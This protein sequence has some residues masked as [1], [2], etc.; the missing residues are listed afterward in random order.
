VT[1]G[2]RFPRVALVVFA[3][4]LLSAGLSQGASAEASVTSSRA[5]ASL[6]SRYAV[7]SPGQGAARA[8]TMAQ[9]RA[10]VKADLSAAHVQTMAPQVMKSVET[11][12]GARGIRKARGK[13]VAPARAQAP[14][15]SI[16][17]DVGLAEVWGPGG[18]VMGRCFDIA[19][20]PAW[21]GDAYLGESLSVQA[22]IVTEPQG[23][24]V[25]G[26][27]VQVSFQLS[28]NGNTSAVFGVS[29]VF[30]PDIGLDVPSQ[31]DF[32]GYI[33]K[34]G[35]FTSPAGLTLSA[36]LCGSG[37]NANSG[38]NFQLITT[39]T[40]TDPG[41]TTTSATVSAYELNVPVTQT[42]AA[43]CS[44][45]GA[46]A[47][48]AQN[49]QLDPVATATGGCVEIA[50]DAIVQA[51]AV[52]MSV[53]RNYSSRQTAAGPLGPGW[54][55]PWFASAAQQGNGDVVITDENGDQ[56][57]YYKNG[58]GSFTGPVGARSALAAASPGW[59]WT[60]PDHRQ[61][62]FNGSGQ[63]AWVHDS[64]GRG[65]S[66]AYTGGQLATVMAASG[67]S[68]ALAYGSG[69][70]LASITLPGGKSVSYGY[71]SGGRLATATDATGNV[72]TYAYTSAGLL[73]SATDGAG[74]VLFTN[75]YDSGGRVTQQTDAAGNMA[76]FAYTPLGNGQ[77]ET[78]MTDPQ[79][80]IWTDVY[81]GNMLVESLNPAGT[82]TLHVANQFLQPVST[83][84]QNGGVSA[85]TYDGSGNRT[86]ATDADS[87]SQAWAYTGNDV[88]S[89]TSANGKV[90]GY[91][92]NAMHEQTSVTA[93][94]GGKTTYA[95]DSA[96]RLTSVTDPRG[97]AS[98]AT[99]S[100]Y[101]TTYAYDSAG[102]LAQKS[103]PLG[104]VNSY[105]YDAM[106]NLA[107]QTDPL[108]HVTTYAYDGDGRLLSV[109]SPASKVTRYAYDAAG[110][111]VSSTDPAG[112]V[113]R[114]AYDA[115]GQLTSTTDPL[116]NVTKYGYDARGNKTTATDPLDNVTNYAYDASNRL[117]SVTDPAGGVSTYAY[118]GDG[119][120]TSQTDP[121]GN[122]TT[123][124]FDPAGNVASTTDP[125]GNQTIYSYNGD[126]NNVST[127]DPLGNATTDAYDSDGRLASVTRPGGGA[128]TYAYD[129]AGNK[130]SVTNPDGKVGARFFPAGPVRLMDTR[131]G[132]GGTTGPVAAGATVR[133]QVA[134]VSGVPSSGVTSVVL[135]LTAVSPSG[136]GFLEAYPDGTTAPT[137][138]DV[139]FGGG[140]TVANMITVPLGADGKV[141]ILVGGTG[142]VQILADLA[143]YLY[144]APSAPGSVTTYAYDADNEMVSQADADGNVTRYAYNADGQLIS[145]TDP[146][147][148][149][150][151]YAYDADG[152]QASATA[153]DGGVT[154]Y[155][156][157]AAGNPVSR[158]D[159]DGSTWTSA[160]D[161]AGHLV[162]TTDPLGKSTTYAYDA[163]GRQVTKTHANG[164]TTTTSHD[165]DSRPVKIT[166]SDGTPTVTY[167]Y[168]KAGNQT[169]ITD[170]T[171]TRTFAYDKGRHLTSAG[172]F[173]YTYDADGDIT[174]R[175][176]P[177]GTSYAYAYTPDG[178]VSSLTKGSTTT[179]YAYTQA[180]N[181]AF[182]TAPDGV[183]ETRGYDAAGQ[184]TSITDATVSATLDSYQLTL[185]ADGQ[186]TQ[187]AVTQNATAQPT[188]YYGYDSTGRLTSECRSSSGAS[189]CSAATGNQTTYA[190]DVAGNLTS[191]ETNGVTTTRSYNADEELTTSVTGSATTNYG[192]NADGQQTTA[193][194]TTYTYNAAG[195]LTGA[196]TPAGNYAYGYD[197][198]GNLTSASLNG[199]K[200]AGTAWDLN[201]PVPMAAEDMNAAGATTADYAWNPSGTL[202]SM[203]TAAGTD[204][205]V[206][207]WLGSLT[208]LVTSSG[209]Q[210]TSTT[211][212]AYGT[213][214]TTGTPASPIGYAASY[215]L[216]GSG[217][218]DMR[219]R[220]YNPA[221]GQFTS[222]DPALATTGQPYAYAGDAPTYRTDPTGRIETGFM[223]GG[224]G[225]GAA[226]AAAIVGFGA[227]GSVCAVRAYS[228][229][230]IGFTVTSQVSFLGAGA[231]AGASFY[232]LVANA[233]E[234]T[235]MHG[236]F[237]AVN[238]GIS[239][240]GTL[241]G[242]FFWSVNNGFSGI[243]GFAGGPG[244]APL[245][246]GPGG[247]SFWIQ[248][249]FATYQFPGWLTGLL[250]WTNPVDPLI[251]QLHWGRAK[252]QNILT[253]AYAAAVSSQAS[254]LPCYSQGATGEKSE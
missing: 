195:N 60:A 110:N 234:I 88:T 107:T 55:M 212:S 18:N 151:A 236:P 30:A 180:G 47:G 86:T 239:A 131:T 136:S 73:A 181:L 56:F 143:G 36:S 129:L 134:G 91:T 153:P 158:T 104:R 20:G 224:C 177:D 231:A 63:L 196:S 127:T 115:R 82:A 65:L 199:T 105:T 101:T 160:Y 64:T 139:S 187:A 52:P 87:N 95:Y 173:T 120:K 149:V 233:N 15:V 174:S 11:R 215:A 12:L 29:T 31:A 19:C 133:L 207:D 141:A 203:T 145:V 135:N 220:D 191:T 132:S 2:V 188:R 242:E 202:A 112:N 99:A 253:A 3:V 238:V 62:G 102:Q 39:A 81:G 78:D 27:N 218:D 118:D 9:R 59:V 170:G 35:G 17:P 119:N 243:F 79:G 93:P 49:T 114:Y 42:A 71:D 69:G 128:T 123:Y 171:G 68:A 237:Y 167:A 124:G 190:Y 122:T 168:D 178:Q 37:S 240:L 144:G 138:S 126:G 142:S 130:T 67:A 21:S 204:Y 219:A 232:G 94:D 32:Y 150:T 46:G 246:I 83:T 24:T 194:S 72:T 214:S 147:G 108:G 57:R 221:L 208:G 217:L 113:T 84:D 111:K 48:N 185:T 51:P 43:P 90:T 222:V 80:G 186:P 98:G 16:V 176:Y 125:L 44:D 249:T 13:P 137:V 66:M 157:D 235:D 117:A 229:N 247:A 74:H 254:L 154:G 172:G 109:T 230:Q 184:L 96:G 248:N 197:A 159:P 50:H 14:A 4:L 245:S 25:V 166:Y 211:Y 201:N 116:G 1:D 206:S 223:L 148:N 53:T 70:Q 226:Y 89:Y 28:C 164:V 228:S 75:A 182:T 106:G 26:N 179:S 192:Y 210:V 8:Q 155:G 183:T 85:A 250:E 175:K 198:A 22:A 10:K 100:A 216:P 193:G 121:D 156:Y 92:Y 163:D 200:I 227:G 97:N 58:D 165:A 189:A 33:K 169:G 213:P 41:G 76:T 162:K 103:D 252:A 225:T 209:T 241:S 251:S 45:S 205:A 5:N 244:I 61:L 77:V 54:T 146:A 38:P 7:G 40:V 161:A 23:G 6:A 152:R 140:L 34:T